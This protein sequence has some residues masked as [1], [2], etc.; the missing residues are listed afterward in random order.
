[1]AT[2]D[3]HDDGVLERLKA[4]RGD[5]PTDPSMA[6][7]AHAA[8]TIDEEPHAPTVREAALPN[9]RRQSREVSTTQHAAHAGDAGDKGAPLDPRH[10]A[11][12]PADSAVRRHSRDLVPPPSEEGAFERTVRRHSRD[13][14]PPPTH[15][16]VDAGLDSTVQRDQLTGRHEVPWAEPG[17]A[18]ATQRRPAVIRAN[19]AIVEPPA[20]R[21][22]PEL[23]T[24]PGVPAAPLEVTTVRA[25]S[26]ATDPLIG[27]MLGEYRVLAP[28]GTGGMGVVYRGEHPVIGRPVAI[29]LLRREYAND[30]DHARR[31]LE[32]ARSLSIARH[33][34]IID[35]FS[36]GETPAGDAFLVMEL[37]EG[38]SLEQVLAERAPLSP[39][40]TLSICIPMLSGL[41]A[42]HAAGVI[43][44]DLKP[45][46]VFLLRLHDGSVFPKL[47]DFGLARRG[48]K[49]ARS[50]RQTSVGGTPLYVA[51]EQARGE[52][53]GPYTDLYSFGCVLYEMLSGH[54]PFT[55]A[56]LHELLDAHRTLAPRPLRT[57]APQVPAEFD[58]LVMRLL[59]KD[60]QKRPASAQEVKE[61]LE[62]LGEALAAGVV[63]TRVRPVAPAADAASRETTDEHPSQGGGSWKVPVALV[64]VIAV[65][66]G[67]F[68]ALR[69]PD[70]TPRPPV[71]PVVE[72]PPPVEVEKPEPVQVVKP[73]PVEVVKPEP[74]P[75][76]PK[77]PAKAERHTQKDVNKKWRELNQRAKTLPEDLRRAAKLQLDEARYCSAAPDKCWSELADI[78]K[79]FFKK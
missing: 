18:D 65:L 30:P 46:N 15:A 48:E 23:V 41:G 76:K 33:P 36:F 57:S 78:E 50:L 20:V 31:F 44:R 8:L 70:E 74:Q 12:S 2:D 32:E 66:G 40:E 9:A 51:P 10:A 3:A 58:K 21:R 29:K 45:G 13:I 71:K 77:A 17:D 67:A 22:Q 35:V 68:V 61:Q 79:T 39:K 28:L 52:N 25:I 64:C 72:L 63:P 53:V 56:N 19:P 1:M 16:G 75:P 6:R 43:H 11:G 27:A 42:A 24:G 73:E 14:V 54:P 38:Q 60:P 47:L 7:P 26:S 55:S 4:A 62:R 34:N 5:A 69:L 37:L 49:G 59:E